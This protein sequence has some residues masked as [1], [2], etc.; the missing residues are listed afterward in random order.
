MFA[1]VVKNKDEN[2]LVIADGAAFGSEIQ[3]MMRLVKSYPNIKLYLPE[4]FE[5]L[6]LKSGL[7][8]QRSIIQMLENPE[9]QIESK[10]FFSWERFFTAQLRKYT[11]ES[12]L[13]YTKK[14]LN[15]AYLQEK[16][17]D[18]ILKVM[19]KIDLR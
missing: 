1:S 11:K 12:Y 9:K 3:K 2:V 15:P 17:V 18:K 5:W 4:S 8:E 16:I 6:I 13:K 10:V 7:I 19:N 14:K